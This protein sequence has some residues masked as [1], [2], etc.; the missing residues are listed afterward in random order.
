MAETTAPATSNARTTTTPD[1]AATTSRRDNLVIMVLI[2]S[3]FTVILNETIMGVAIPHLMADLDITAV[4]AQWLTAAFLLTMAVVIPITG[5]LLQRFP[6]RPLYLAAM[7]T[8]VAGTALAAVAPGFEVLLGA[9]VIQATG[10]AVMLPLLMTTVISLVP[11]H[12]RG[13][14]MGTIG[15][16]ISVAP[17]L[18]PTISG[19]ILQFLPWRFLFVFVLPVAI[20]VLVFGFLKMRST[21]ETRPAP[22]DLP[23]VLLAAVGFGSLVF[24][25]SQIGESAEGNVLVAIAFAVIG[26]VVTGVFA[27]RQ[28]VLQKRDAPLL[29]LRVFRERT[30]S[31]ATAMFVVAMMA[32][33]GTIILVPLFTQGVL[34]LSVLQTGLMLLPGGLLMG[35]MAR[36]VGRLYDR[37]GPRPLLIPGTALV[38]TALW[39]LALTLSTAT[40]PWMVLAC[41]VTLSAGLALIFTPLFTASLGSLPQHL[42]SHGSATISTL[43]QVAAA[44]GTALFVSTMTAVAITQIDGGASEATAEAAGIRTAFLV[45]AILATLGIGLATLIRR[46]EKVE[47]EAPIAAH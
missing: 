40:Q 24:G 15:L 21:N 47:G 9:R 25:L 34:G 6:T 5:W 22:L 3:A 41:H 28:I 36:P 46:P 29:D 26:V 12:E 39:M 11:E 38:A 1:A 45:G 35:V 4:D 37:I 42:Y 43:Q 33:F 16:V 30:F 27:W 10:T 17:A 8:F 19:V 23:S 14:R 32:L 31:V 20:T 2:V 13:K 18:G 7:S 44:A